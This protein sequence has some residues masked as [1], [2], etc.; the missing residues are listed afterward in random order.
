[1]SEVIWWVGA[2]H[3]GAYA[4]GGFL[5][6]SVIAGEWALK[7]AGFHRKVLMALWLYYKNKAEVNDA[8]E[9]EAAR[10]AAR[11]AKS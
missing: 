5:F 6:A 1:M 4:L 2:V 9:R 8:L 3:I 11:D 7:K 10:K